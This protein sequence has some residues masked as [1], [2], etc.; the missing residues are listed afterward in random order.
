MTIPPDLE[1][2]I[3]IIMSIFVTI[4]LPGVGW[5][6]VRPDRGRRQ[7]PQLRRHPR[8]DGCL[9]GGPAQSGSAVMAASPRG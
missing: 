5:R 9:S 2:Q 7:D 8:H 4:P 3:L 6:H 1:A